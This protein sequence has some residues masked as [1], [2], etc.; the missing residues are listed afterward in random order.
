M[1]AQRI[2]TAGSDLL[3]QTGSTLTVRDSR[4]AIRNPTKTT[5][6]GF[7]SLTAARKKRRTLEKKKKYLQIW[8][9][10]G[11][12]KCPWL[13]AR[14]PCPVFRSLLGQSVTIINIYPMP[15]ELHC[16][17]LQCIIIVWNENDYQISKM[18][19]Y[20]SSYNHDVLVVFDV[21][22]T[23]VSH[24]VCVNYT[25]IDSNGQIIQNEPWCCFTFWTKQCF[26]ALPVTLILNGHYW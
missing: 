12:Y 26:Y 19:L 11:K 25:S 17:L 14:S 3:L 2:W 13:E 15:H 1:R 8:L 22:T 10:Q 4:F 18:A 24:T 5:G 7:N 16:T 9:T 6:K 20:V 23:A 21:H